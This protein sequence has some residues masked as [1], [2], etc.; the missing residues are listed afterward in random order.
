MMASDCRITSMFM[1]SFLQTEIRDS[2]P[3]RILDNHD[4]SVAHQRT[5]D[6]NVDVVSGRAPHAYN[7]VCSKLQN[8]SDGH[9]TAAELYFHVDRHVRQ[10]GDLLKRS[11]D[12]RLSVRRDQIDSGLAEAIH[13]IYDFGVGLIAALVDDQVGEFR[14]NVHV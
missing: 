10:I 11:H 14:R 1:G 13:G 3:D 2:N 12:R 9:D 4:L 5:A 7:A 6:Q 8:L